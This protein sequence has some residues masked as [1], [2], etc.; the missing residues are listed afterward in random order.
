MQKRGRAKDSLGADEHKY[1][2]KYLLIFLN[3]LMLRHEAF[4]HFVVL[5]RR[6]ATVIHRWVRWQLLGGSTFQSAQAAK[7][8]RAF[9]SVKLGSATSSS[10]LQLWRGYQKPEKR[11]GPF[12]LADVAGKCLAEPELLKRGVVLLRVIQT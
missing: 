12:T 7:L 11:L 6:P 5:R 2:Y 3:A 4:S 8:A 1:R 10:R 9:R